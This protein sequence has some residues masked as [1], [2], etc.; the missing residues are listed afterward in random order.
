MA[1]KAT[2]TRTERPPATPAEAAVEFRNR[3][4]ESGLPLGGPLGDGAPRTTKER[5]LDTAITMFAERGFE[6]ATMRDLAS[7]VGIKAP[8]IYNHYASKEEVLAE[9]MEQML[10]Q[11]FAY[12]LGPLE[13]EPVERWLALI[14]RRHV[15]FQLNLPRLSQALDT[16]LYS[17][18]S[19]HNLPKAVHRRLV[20]AARDYVELIRS[21]VL[22]LAREMDRHDALL[23]AFAITATGDRVGSWFDPAGPLDRE[24][25]ADRHWALFKRLVQSA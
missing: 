19:E 1:A 18:R 10:G 2:V 11:F 8:A 20:R 17:P 21:A 16:L 7:E 22:V 6:A 14:V 5:I 4:L 24:E 23:I 12:V 13:D 15:M 3:V 25:I 9:A